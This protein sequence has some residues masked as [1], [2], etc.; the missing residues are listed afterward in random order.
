MPL[1]PT[2]TFLPDPATLPSPAVAA[3]TQT[4]KHAAAT[5]DYESTAHNGHAQNQLYWQPYRRGEGEG[6]GEGEERQEGEGGKE[7]C[8]HTDITRQPQ[9]V[10]HSKL[11]P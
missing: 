7:K 3:D 8:L 9:L 4:H 6:E 11:S 1:P 10:T 5:K 2:P